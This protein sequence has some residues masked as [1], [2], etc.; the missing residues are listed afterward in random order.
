M[1]RVRIVAVDEAPLRLC[2]SLAVS[3]RGCS[4]SVMLL[5]Y[6]DMQSSSQARPSAIHAGLA[7]WF[8]FM[9]YEAALS[10][11]SHG[12]TFYCYVFLGVF[13]PLSG[14][15]P[16]PERYPTSSVA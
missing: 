15:K 6:L 4:A 7:L 8:S 1:H 10:V 5:L 12:G 11:M 14:S 2:G 13:W 9:T 3:R 16:A